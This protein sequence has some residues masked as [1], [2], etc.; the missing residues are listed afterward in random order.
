MSPSHH[1]TFPCKSDVAELTRICLAANF[2]PDLVWVELLNA[3]F[4]A[5]RQGAISEAQFLAIGEL[6]PRLFSELVPAATLLARAERWGHLLDHP[7]YDCL[8][9]VL[10]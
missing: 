10:S 2:A 1:G 4:Q 7:A 3:G 6:A 9:L 5:Q 8:H